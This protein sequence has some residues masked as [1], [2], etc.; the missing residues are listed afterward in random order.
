MSPL[1][2][3]FIQESFGFPQLSVVTNS[4]EIEQYLYALEEEFEGIVLIMSSG[5]LGGV[6][7]KEIFVN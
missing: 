1:E 5:Q 4:N 3:D 2:T 6:H 7:L